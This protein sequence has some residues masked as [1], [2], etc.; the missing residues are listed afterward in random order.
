MMSKYQKKNYEE[1]TYYYDETS[2]PHCGHYFM[3]DYTYL[4]P[5][6]IDG[7]DDFVD[8]YCPYC[9]KVHAEHL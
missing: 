6:C 8:I 5:V 2:C 7:D 9:R 1:V 4:K 3:V